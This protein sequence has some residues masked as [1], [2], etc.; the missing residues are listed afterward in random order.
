MF[1]S[2]TKVYNNWV[3]HL[4]AFGWLYQLFTVQLSLTHKYY[5][6]SYVSYMG[7]RWGR[8]YT[9]YLIC[10]LWEERE[11]KNTR[12]YGASNLGIVVL[13]FILQ[14]YQPSKSTFYA[15]KKKKVSWWEGKM[16]CISWTAWVA[17]ARVQKAEERSGPFMKYYTSSL[18]PCMYFAL[19]ACEKQQ[20]CAITRSCKRL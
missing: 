11:R 2:C 12:L 9:R 16:L 20:N 19:F 5:S 4:I 18:I 1:P 13:S 14:G 17:F 8:N 15:T 3:P 7:L 6:P 10:A